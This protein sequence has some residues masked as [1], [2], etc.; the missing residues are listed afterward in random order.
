M[1][2]FYGRSEDIVKMKNKLIKEDFK[3]QILINQGYVY[4]W[5]QFSGYKDRDIEI[6]RKRDWKFKID[7]NGI[8][9]YFAF[10]YIVIIYL[11]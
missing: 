9:A 10:I 1:L 6:I 2:P 11:G 3:V 4:T 7:K 5:L 8:I